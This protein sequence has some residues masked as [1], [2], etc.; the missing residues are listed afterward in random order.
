MA[1]SFR[2]EIATVR[3]LRKI[4]AKRHQ[5]QLEHALII[6][7]GGMRA[8]RGLSLHRSACPVRL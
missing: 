4:I 6:V 8:C 2:A 5:T 1:T 7:G 3:A